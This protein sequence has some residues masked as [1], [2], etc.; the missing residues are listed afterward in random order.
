MSSNPSLGMKPFSQVTPLT[1]ACPVLWWLWG[2]FSHPLRGFL[3]A[4]PLTDLEQPKGL[5]SGDVLNQW[6]TDHSGRSLLLTA[7]TW[8]PCLGACPAPGSGCHHLPPWESC[9]LP[10]LFLDMWNTWGLGTFSYFFWIKEFPPSVNKLTLQLISWDFCG[11]MGLRTHLVSG[12]L[13]L[14]CGWGSR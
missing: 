1:T 11:Q 12:V 13:R 8:G 6:E 3:W 4:H 9:F 14:L 5:G 2:Y 7:E 10:R